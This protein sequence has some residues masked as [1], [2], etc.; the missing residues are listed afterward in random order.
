MNEEQN[1][2]VKQICNAVD[3]LVDKARPPMESLPATI[4]AAGAQCMPGLSK[5]EIISKVIN[6]LPEA[7][8]PNTENTDGSANLI[9]SLVK[10]IVE[11]IVDAIRLSTRVQGGIMPFGIQIFGTGT[12][13]GGPFT[14]TGY[15]INAIK[16]D[17]ICG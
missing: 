5:M 17:G 4:V 9:N 3:A 14:F 12:N 6:R 8:I 2:N 1:I 10:I 16:V 11:E 13:A 7:G 15:N